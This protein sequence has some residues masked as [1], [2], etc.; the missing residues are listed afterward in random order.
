MKSILV[1][2]GAGFIGS[3][4]VV[5]LDAAGYRPV[6]V[7]NFSNSEP[8]VIKQLEKLLKKS[9]PFYEQD[10]KDIDKL[11]RLISNEDITGIIHFAAYKAVNESVNE[12]L[13][14]Y[15]NNVGGLIELLQYLETSTV[16]NI[17]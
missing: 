4:A 9:V 16:K 6:I 15:E 7:D 14:Y 17:V 2:G 13:K 10:Y 5:E 8:K 3:H 12:P 1:T 11:S